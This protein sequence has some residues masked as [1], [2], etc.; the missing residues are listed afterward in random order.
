[1]MMKRSAGYFFLA[2]IA[3]AC[4]LPGP[5]PRAEFFKYID[6]NG[7]LRF[8]DDPA[9]IPPAYRKSAQK[10]RGAY[11]HLSP[12]ERQRLQEREREDERE[13]QAEPMAEPQPAEKEPT[14]EQILG[15]EEKARETSETETRVLVRGDQVLVPVTLGYEENEVEAL[16]LLDTGSSLITLHQKLADQLNIKAFK[17]ARALVAGGRVVRFKLVRLT[18]IQVGPQRLEDVQ[19]GIIKNQGPRVEHDGLLGMNFLRKF[20]YSIDYEKQ[21]IRWLP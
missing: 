20:R 12:E 18:Y 8:V 7:T 9:K 1:M 3:A 17:S 11:D 5:A 15:L 6:K 21:V 13:R 16:L 14:L 10:Y 19:A 2:F 4:F